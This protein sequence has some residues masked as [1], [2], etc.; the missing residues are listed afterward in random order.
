MKILFF[1]DVVGRLGRGAVKRF[2]DENREEIAPDLIVANADNIAGGK[3][4]TI[5][6][7]QEMLEIGVDVMTS[8]DHIW[9]NKDAIEIIAKK[10]GKLL[11]PENYPDICPGKGHI[12]V[13]V[14]GRKVLVAC[15]LGRTWTKEGLDSPFISA[16]KV[17]ADTKADIIIYDFHSEA[18]SEINA[19]GW[20]FA[21]KV[22]ALLGTHTHVQTADEKIMDTTAY[23]SDVGFCGP[24]HSVIGV[25]PED[26]IALFRTG[27]Q[28]SLNLAK[29][30]SQV[31]AV[32]VEI[33]D[34]NGQAIK[35]DRINQVYN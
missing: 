16:D 5:A 2:L 1:G 7:Y 3:G 23:I 27:I 11:R 17:L 12:E 8:G 25:K 33:D 9:D 10:E 6:T 4:P 34:K 29:G 14:N 31:N 15:F 13:E 35:I 18:T 21:G 26:S 19:F 22:S 20:D 28:R 24:H 32:L 30:A